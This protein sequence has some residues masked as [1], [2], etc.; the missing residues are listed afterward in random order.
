MHKTQNKTKHNIKI[1]RIIQ[2]IAMFEF[3]TKIQTHHFKTILN[4][5]NTPSLEYTN[6]LF[7]NNI[8]V[9]KVYCGS[10]FEPGASELPGRAARLSPQPPRATRSPPE[11]IRI[12]FS[13]FVFS[14]LR[15][16]D[17]IFADWRA[18]RKLARSSAGALQQRRRR[19]VHR[20]VWGEQ[21]GHGSCRGWDGQG[22]GSAVECNFWQGNSFCVCPHVAPDAVATWM[23]LKVLD[24]KKPFIIHLQL[25]SSRVEESNAKITLAHRYLTLLVR[26]PAVIGELAVWRHNNKSKKLLEG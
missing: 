16:P 13:V 2:I 24:T 11:P 17:A 14:F 21:G 22:R 10:A 7:Q 8:H 25:L 4:I 23:R 5:L 20:V 3:T 12:S 9:S 6:T 15:W 1:I 26:V 19:M 18:S